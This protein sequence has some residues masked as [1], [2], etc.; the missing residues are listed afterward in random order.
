[1]FLQAKETSREFTSLPFVN[2]TTIFSSTP[3]SFVSP[4]DKL[5]PSTPNPSW[6]V[7]D[8]IDKSTFLPSLLYPVTL[9]PVVPS[10]AVVTSIIFG[11]DTIAVIV[12]S[13]GVIVSV[14]TTDT[15]VVFKG[16]SYSVPPLFTSVV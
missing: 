7:P 11:V 13:T 9:T 10:V 14:T 12:T 1:M 3:N 8:I 16:N 2:S 15:G 4:F 5:L 6:S